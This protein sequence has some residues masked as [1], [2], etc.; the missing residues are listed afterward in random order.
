MARRIV[1][2]FGGSGFVGRHLVKRLVKRGYTVRVAVRD[3]ESAHYLLP[4]GDAG[5][6]VPWPCDI[7]A[8]G[9]P[10]RALE[11]AVGAVNLVGILY[12]RGERTFDAVHVGAATRIAEAVAAAGIKRF[13]HMSAL[14]ADAES[15][16]DYARTK[17]EAETAVLA[18]MPDAVIVRPSVIFGPEDDFFNKFASIGEISPV[19]PIIGAATPIDDGPRFQ[20]VYVGDVAEAIAVALES[21]NAAGQTFELGGPYVYCFRE[22]IELIPEITHRKRILMAVPYVLADILA[23]VLGLLPKPPLT[24]DQVRLLRR[25]N[26]CS[27]TCPGLAE[28]GIEAQTVE[29]IV[30]TYLN[31]FRDGGRL[32]R[33]A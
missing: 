12:E 8:P 13:V 20:P 22:I 28:L 21:P 2:V 4:M 31:R 10:A 23:A 9:D 3:V 19:L 30:P 29:A 6:V 26:V 1:T 32:K 17:G 7:C 11:G 24:L 15:D 5:Q 18:A 33:F 14:G 16:S 25:D 27:G